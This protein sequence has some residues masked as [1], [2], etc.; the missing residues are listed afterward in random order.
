MGMPPLYNITE[1]VA[2][3]W[4]ATL[5]SRLGWAQDNWQLHVTGGLALTHLTLDLAYVNNFG[6]LLAAPDPSGAAGQTSAATTKVGWTI[7]A[8]GEYALDAHWSLT[9]QYLYVDFGSVDASVLVVNPSV[10]FTSTIDASADFTT[11]L[12]L[13]GI[14]YHFDGR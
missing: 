7:G 10:A 3:D 5:R 9:A 12:A 6:P 4:I 1:R 2:A 14:T 13:A 8:G 11:S